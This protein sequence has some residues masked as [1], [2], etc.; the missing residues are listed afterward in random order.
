M[1]KQIKNYEG[2]YD[3]DQEGNVY[4]LDRTITR[5]TVFRNGKTAF[6]EVFVKGCKLKNY[7][8]KNGYY[9]V[10]LN[11]NGKYHQRYVHSLVAEAFFG[12]RPNRY[13]VNHI[14]GNKLNNHISNLDY[15][16]YLENNKHAVEMGL[17]NHNVGDYAISKPIAMICLKTG[18]Q[19]ERFDSI[20]SAKEK[21]GFWHIGSVA[22]KQRKSAGG[23]GWIFV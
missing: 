4:G 16:T 9:V 13:T 21:Y 19:I 10:N 1:R 7:K 23:Y 22:N 6:Q 12:E 2:L 15:C 20:T 11:K 8:A 14:D 3:V 17:N 5:K 18:K